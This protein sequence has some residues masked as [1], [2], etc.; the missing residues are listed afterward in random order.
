MNSQYCYLSNSISLDVRAYFGGYP[1]LVT[2]FAELESEANAAGRDVLK[3]HAGKNVRQL[4]FICNVILV[5]HFLFSRAILG[6]FLDA[7]AT[8]SPGQRKCN[9]IPLRGNQMPECSNYY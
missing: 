9:T 3:L 6:Q 4:H 5:P 2:A 7:Q 1:R 8:Q